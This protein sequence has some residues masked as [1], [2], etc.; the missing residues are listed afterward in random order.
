MTTAW[1]V[2]IWTTCDVVFKN[3]TAVVAFAT[4][5]MHFVQIVEVDVLRTVE[6]TVVTCVVGLPPGGVVM[7]VTG[8]DVVVVMTL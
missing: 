7:L 1:V 8:Q 2:C 6:R 4:G 5:A 3:G